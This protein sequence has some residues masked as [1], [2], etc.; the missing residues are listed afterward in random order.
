MFFLYLFLGIRPQGFRFKVNPT[1]L[2]FWGKHF[3]NYTY[4]YHRRID[5]RVIGYDSYLEREWG[6]K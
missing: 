2:R 6:I 5:E 4:S 1:A 3:E